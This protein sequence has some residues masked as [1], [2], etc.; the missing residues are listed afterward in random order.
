[1]VRGID[2][3]GGGGGGGVVHRGEGGGM[4]AWPFDIMIFILVSF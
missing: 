3:G 4:G 1:M 2:V